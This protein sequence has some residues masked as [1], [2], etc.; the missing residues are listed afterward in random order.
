MRVLIV[1]DEPDIVTTTAELLRLVGHDVVTTSDWRQ[2]PDLATDADI[3]LHDVRMPGLDIARQ[4]RDLRRRFAG[5]IVLFTA[6]R[7]LDP[8][9][10]ALDVDGLLRKPFGLD[11]AEAVLA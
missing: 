5:R 10:A 4:V 1:D 6:E 3:I 7:I 2:V 8:D 11:E 9:V